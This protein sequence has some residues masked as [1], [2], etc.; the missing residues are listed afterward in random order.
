MKFQKTQA[1][2]GLVAVKVKSVSCRAPMN[3]VRDSG[4]GRGGD[5]PS[6]PAQAQA[7]FS[8]FP[9]KKETLIEQS[10]IL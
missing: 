5:F 2:S 1:G 9:I 6:F 7:E 10:R 3:F 4:I 8:I